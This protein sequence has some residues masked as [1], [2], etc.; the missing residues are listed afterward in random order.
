M[1]AAQ[2]LG[3]QHEQGP[4]GQLPCR[5][6]QELLRALVDVDDGPRG[7][8]DHDRVAEPVEEAPG[9][10]AQRRGA[11]SLLGPG[12]DDGAGIQAGVR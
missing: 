10:E 3:D 9:V 2:A 1:G 4:A 11:V 12:H 5:G 6:T 7:V 8:G